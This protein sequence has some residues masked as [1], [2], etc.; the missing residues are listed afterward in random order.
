MSNIINIQELKKRISDIMSW[1]LEEKAKHEA[2]NNI[3]K[4]HCY[5]LSRQGLLNAEAIGKKS[6]E[7]LTEQGVKVNKEKLRPVYQYLSDHF[8]I[9]KSEF[10]KFSKM[11]SSLHNDADSILESWFKEN[12]SNIKEIHRDRYNKWKEIN[13]T[14]EKIRIDGRIVEK[15]YG[16]FFNYKS[17]LHYL[18]LYFEEIYNTWEIECKYQDESDFMKE[19]EERCNNAVKEK[20]RG[21]SLDM[22]LKEKDLK[23]I[24]ANGLV[25]PPKIKR[26]TDDLTR[27]FLNWNAP[28]SHVNQFGSLLIGEPGTGKTSFGGL[29]AEQRDKNC[30]YIYSHASEITSTTSLKRIFSLAKILEPCVVQIDDI[31]LICADRS[32]K[33]TTDEEQGKIRMTSELMKNL[34]GL[35]NMG[36]I[37]VIMTSNNTTNIDDAV[38][39]RA[40]RISGKIVFNEFGECVPELFELFTK[41]YGLQLNQETVLKVSESMKE[42]LKDF[43]PDEVKNCCE[44]LHLMYGIKEITQDEFQNALTKTYNAFHNPYYKKSFLNRSKTSLSKTK[45]NGKVSN[46]SSDY[47]DAMLENGY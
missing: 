37:F 14:P 43:T 38:F 6:K 23:G 13:D 16:V 41:T 29:L 27:C 1:F 32:K 3:R 46:N 4:D 18:H 24:F 2:L 8:S 5:E 36:K 26:E 22:Y 33:A 28:T 45:K 31:D 35:E 11:E 10:D 30:T 44:Y 25:F 7:W 20:C 19:F 34:D 12:G 21:K 17:R 47:Y 39:Y 15:Q 40:G 42:K 9:S